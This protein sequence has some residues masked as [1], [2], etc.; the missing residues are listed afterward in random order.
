MADEAPG[1]AS[2]PFERRRS[3]RTPS[4]RATIGIGQVALILGVVALVLGGSGLVISLTNSSHKGA[5]GG[6]GPAGAQGPTGA[7]GIP[8]I[9]GTN[10]KAGSNGTNGK[11]GIPGPGAVANLSYDVQSTALSTTCTAYAGSDV[12]FTVSGPGVL[13]VTASVE[14]TLFHTATNYTIYSVSFGNGSKMCNAFGNN[15]VAGE[16][17]GTDPTG[18]S[19]VFLGLAQSFPIAGTG[20]YTVD[21]VGYASMNRSLDVTYLTYASVSGVFYPS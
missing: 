5:P 4:L 11:Q 1:D 15:S 2:N 6:T 19:N 16:A 21:V 9:N 7:R 18:Y 10:G 3:R 20:T 14:V 8:G 13:V 17:F 12:N